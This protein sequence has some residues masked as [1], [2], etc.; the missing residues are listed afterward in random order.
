MAKASR[1]FP[2]AQ[3]DCLQYKPTAIAQRRMSLVSLKLKST[4]RSSHLFIAR[5]ILKGIQDLPT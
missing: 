5:R 3:N 4:L 2:I 1:Q